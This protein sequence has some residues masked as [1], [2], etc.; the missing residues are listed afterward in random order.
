MRKKE[1]IEKDGV[2][3]EVVRV[4]EKKQKKVIVNGLDVTDFEDWYD[5]GYCLEAVKRNGYSLRYV[6]KRVFKK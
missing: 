4:I 5:P 2:K 6:D 1:I 3:Y